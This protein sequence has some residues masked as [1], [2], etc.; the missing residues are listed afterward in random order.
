MAGAPNADPALPKLGAGLVED[1]PKIG[2]EGVAADP[3]AGGE[4]VGAE[5]K[6][7]AEVVGTEPKIEAVESGAEPKTDAEVVGAAPKAGAEVVVAEPNAGTEVVGTEPKIGA[8]EVGAEP[9]TDADVVGAEPKAGADVVDAEPK[10]GADAVDAEPKTGA[11]VVGAEPKATLGFETFPNI[12]DAV[13]A[14]NIGA[15]VV[16]VEVF[17]NTDPTTDEV[18]PKAGELSAVLPKIGAALVGLLTMLGIDGFGAPKIEATVVA[19][20]LSPKVKGLLIG[21]AFEAPFSPNVKLDAAA[22]L[23]VA[24]INEELA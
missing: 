7:G 20:L 18:V 23:V 2:A 13:V 6:L 10:A 9:K 21:V 4:V 12:E 3:K 8:E 16:T 17:P 24:G 11:V 5:P 22:V 14:A 19:G 1:E 15:V